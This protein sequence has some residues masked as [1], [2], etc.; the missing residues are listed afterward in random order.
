ML[1][2]T[3]SM[4]QEHKMVCT[5]YIKTFTKSPF[6]CRNTSFIYRVREPIKKII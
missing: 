2:M 1:E 4:K 3:K 5:N 6:K